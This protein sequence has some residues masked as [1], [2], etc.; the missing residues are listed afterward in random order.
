[1][2]SRVAL[3]VG[4]TNFT[5]YELFLDIG[6]LLITILAIGSFVFEYLATIFSMEHEVKAISL[7]V[8]FSRILSIVLK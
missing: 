3:Q 6:F 4:H 1:V 7:L 8:V 5:K 2:I